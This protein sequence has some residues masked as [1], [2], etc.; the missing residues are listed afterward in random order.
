[1]PADVSRFG[2]GPLLVLV[3]GLGLAVYA[4]MM[5]HEVELKRLR[6]EVRQMLE[7]VGGALSREL[8]SAFQLM[9]G[10]AGVVRVDGGIADEK[11]RALAATLLE[12]NELIRNVA[13]APDNVVRL[14]YPL[15][16]NEAVVGLNYASHPEQWPGVR[17]AMEERRLIVAG[18]VKLVQG[19]RAVIGRRP[20]FVPARPGEAGPDRYWGVVSTVIELDRLL[21]RAPL[22]ES[23]QALDLALRGQDGQGVVGLPFY[24]AERVFAENPVLLE[25]SLP[26]GNWQLAGVPRGGWPPLRLWRS[27]A[28][29]GG[30]LLSL[31]LS[32]L[33]ERTRRSAAA[34][35]QS[36]SLFRTLAEE[37]L[38]GVYLLQDDR[39]LYVNPAVAAILG[40]SRQELLDLPSVLDPVAPEDRERVAR[41]L[42]RR[43]HGEVRIVNQEF[44]ILRPNGQRRLVETLGCI[45]QFQGRPAV[46]GTARDITE[47]REAERRLAQLNRTYAVLSDI[48]QLIVREREPRAILAGAC[49]VATEQGGFRL[50][51]VGLVG[52][53]S[54][55]LTVAAHAGATPDTLAILE[56]MCRQPECG[57]VF[58]ARALAQGRPAVCN[59]VAGDPESAP[60]RALALER[61]YRA[62][63]SLPLRVGE[64]TAGVFNLYAGEAGFFDAEELKLLSELAQDLGFAL[65]YCERERQR[66]EAEE[67]LRT[68]RELFRELAETIEEVF[69]VREAAGNRVLYVSPAYER[70]W[71]RPVR[72]L[73]AA[74]DSWLE[75]VHP[76][77]REQVRAAVA[78]RQSSG[79]YDVEYRIV[80]PDGQVRWIRDRAYP[81][82]T[83]T[84]EVMRLVGVAWDITESRHLAEQLRQAQKM[85]A[86]GLL[87]G[88]VAHDFNN[89]LAV[90]QLQA[91]L[92]TAVP[93]LPDKAREG[94]GQIRAAAE[95]AAR[96]TRQLL[97]FSRREV[98][99]PRVLN[100]NEVIT[101]LAQMLHRVIGEHIE[102]ELRLHPRPLVLRADPGMLD[103]V[104]MNL[105]V[106]ARDAMPRG[107]RLCIETGELSLDAAA[108]RLHPDVA[109][110]RYVW[111]RVSDTGT[112][113]A[114]EH[115]PHIFEPFYTTKGPGKGT[116]L[117]LATVFGIVQQ[118]R[119]WIDVHSEP[120]RGTTFQVHLPAR[121]SPPPGAEPAGPGARLPGGTE[122]ILLVEDEPAVRELTKAV[123]QQAGYHVLTAEHGPAA[124]SVW[125]VQRDG[126]A[127]LVTDL[128]M[129]GG[130]SGREL[131]QRLRAD[132]PALRVIYISG[133]SADVAGTE[134]TPA[135]GELFLPKPFNVETLLRSVRQCLDA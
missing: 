34:A 111:L 8:F 54:G 109:P 87:A 43:L 31:V 94:L 62:M 35:R 23:E 45:T 13:L 84:G 10:I 41:N 92:I 68:S 113:I 108:A 58:T 30:A 51:W 74:P 17:R 102:L 86:I 29:W 69:W 59:D 16:G 42:Q 130:W 60:W 125:Q 103:Q 85:E 61:G 22:A 38:D 124:L 32:G 127:L 107:G 128:V 135:R 134:L 71:G 105:A 50:A 2:L 110:G 21:A 66:R 53:D 115:L 117:G 49:R 4:A 37:A 126:I 118:H 26:A 24:G 77:D 112:G 19:G 64:R 78:H 12:R 73:Y 123:L 82:R 5:R 131:A 25:V 90:M 3:G 132:K 65:E 27:P 63:I 33:I 44:T 11:F 15:E 79:E 46:L 98:M 88:G 93:G 106:N 129:P 116:G 101:A 120:G 20:I 75:A 99:Q 47:R 104:L 1:V 121:A 55:P 7:P 96:L 39:F 119:G 89:I 6:T 81:V 9:E 122:T 48:N 14:V 114:P 97:L 28:F 76:E 40:R 70:I 83:P 72:D 52:D 56:A 100:L 18:P 91:E 67:A 80:R 133:Y 36:E 57:C 95:R